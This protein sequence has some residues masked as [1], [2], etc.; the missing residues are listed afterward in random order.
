MNNKKISL[1]IA[2]S[3]LLLFFAQP[4]IAQK[5]S[6]AV[7]SY[8]SGNPDR[9][10]SFDAKS[11]THIIYCFGHLEGN[12]LKIGRARDTLTIKKMVS[13]KK[14]NPALKVLLSLGGWG[15]CKPCSDVFNTKEGRTEFAQSVKETNQ[16]FGADGIDLDWEYPAIEGYPGH[17]FRPEDKDN[18]TELVQELRNTLGRNQVITFAAGGFQKYVENAVD[19]GKVVPLVDYINLMTY[20]LTSGY[21]PVTG[22]HT[23]LYSSAQQIESTD[24]CVQNLIRLGV[25]PAKLIVGAAFYARIWENVPD[26]NNGLYQPGKFKTSVS[27]KDFPSQLSSANGYVFYWDDSTKAPYAYNASQKLFATYDDKRS[28]ALK[29]KYVVDQK[30]GGIM[31]WEL[32]LDPYKDGLVDT[33]NKMLKKTNKK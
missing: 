29:T 32:G 3:L 10:D 5:N 30:L 25:D 1:I 2:C 31:Y 19:W 11:M 8:F 4:S 22:H 16:Y 26:V 27:F 33:I 18:F 17:T 15:G 7:I 12:R 13:M 6:K 14:K 21:S 23:A 24:N 20:D 9:L 28:V